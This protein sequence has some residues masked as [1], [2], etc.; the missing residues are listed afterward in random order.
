MTLLSGAGRLLDSA[1][2]ECLCSSCGIIVTAWHVT[3][4]AEYAVNESTC[5]S[6][7]FIPQNAEKHACQFNFPDALSNYCC[8]NTAGRRADIGHRMCCG[9]VCRV[10]WLHGNCTHTRDAR[11]QEMAVDVIYF[12]EI[13]R[14]RY[15]AVFHDVI[16][17]RAP[18]NCTPISR[19]RAY[20]GGQGRAPQ[21]RNG[22]K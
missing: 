3:R 14:Y 9:C 16:S 15:T 1:A 4:A 22:R 18:L 7:C 2:V 8:P 12:T 13:P 5:R 21:W 6:C 19:P 20:S 11:Y 10:M 17:C